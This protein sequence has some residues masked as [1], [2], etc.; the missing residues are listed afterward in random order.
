MKT[1]IGK[2]SILKKGALIVFCMQL[3]TGVYAQAWLSDIKKVNHVFANASSFSMQLSVK[4][5]DR[6]AAA[7]PMMTYS[8]KVMKSGSLYFSEM[9]GKVTLLNEKGNLFVDEAQKVVVFRKST[10]AKK[11]VQAPNFTKLKTALH[12]ILTKGA[13]ATYMENSA[14]NKKIRIVN[15]NYVYKTVEISIDPATYAI[16]QVIYYMDPATAAENNVA[17]IVVDYSGV[18]TNTPL[19]SALFSEKKYVLVANGKASLTKAY[20]EFKLIN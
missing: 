11:A 1:T 9:M 20:K 16:R 14:L 13:T 19:A 15:N 17:K 3:L 6:Q 18:Q 5:Y 4:I 2:K 10:G 8:G 7:T 12:S